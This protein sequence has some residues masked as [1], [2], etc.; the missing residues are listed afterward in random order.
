VNTQNT[1]CLTFTSPSEN[2]PQGHI[3]NLVAT[4]AA[5]QAK[6]LGRPF[7]DP[8]TQEE[9]DALRWYLEEYWK[10]PYGGFLERAKEP[11]NNRFQEFS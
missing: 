4:R 7:S 8:L 6:P 11:P 2:S 10:W 5:D 1:V 3:A 9:R